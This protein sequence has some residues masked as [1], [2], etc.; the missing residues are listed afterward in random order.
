MQKGVAPASRKPNTRHSPLE[1]T[2]FWSAKPGSGRIGRVPIKARSVRHEAQLIEKS[3]NTSAGDFSFQSVPFKMGC[4][5]APGLAD[6]VK[7]CLRGRRQMGVV[8]GETSVAQRINGPNF[9][10]ALPLF[11]D[12]PLEIKE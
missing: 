4:Q 10:V 5:A 9:G 6:A 2:A 8:R 12:R 7:S 1:S 3:H 11:I